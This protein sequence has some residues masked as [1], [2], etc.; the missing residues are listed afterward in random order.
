M[1]EIFW[2]KGD[3][4]ADL[5]ILLRPR[6]GKWLGHELQRLRRSGVG[7]LIS[8]LERTE[9]EWLEL[10]EEGKLAVRAGLNFISFPIRDVHV[11]PNTVIFRGFAANLAERLRAGEAIGI[12][13]RGSIGRSTIVAACALIHLGWDAKTALAA[14][15]NA[16]GCQVPETEEQREW[17]LSYQ[18]RP[19]ATSLTS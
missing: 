8:L 15:E 9:A 7:T 1:Q 10:G 6:G 13:C 5:A 18:P 11:P 12:H 19:E 4:P 2:I 17:I 3:P 16:R 14:I